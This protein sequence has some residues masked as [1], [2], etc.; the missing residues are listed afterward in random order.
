MSNTS[1]L[2][3]FIIYLLA[4]IG[5]GVYFFLK[6]RNGKARRKTVTRDMTATRPAE[7]P[8]LLIFPPPFYAGCGR[9]GA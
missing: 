5:V 8:V 1:E 9:E 7:Y 6:T 4:M 2:I 3:V